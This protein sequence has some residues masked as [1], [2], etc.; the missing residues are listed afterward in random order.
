MSHDSFPMTSFFILMTL[1]LE[2]LSMKMC[3]IGDV[4]WIHRAL[5][6]RGKFICQYGIIQKNSWVYE[7]N[8]LG[9]MKGLNTGCPHV[10]WAK[11]SLEVFKSKLLSPEC[12]SKSKSVML[13]SI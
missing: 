10:R 8:I 6:H 4:G 5:S 2:E 11:V 12:L 1:L 3:D 9:Y 7:K 13:S